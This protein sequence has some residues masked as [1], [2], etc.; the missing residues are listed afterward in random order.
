MS[1]D[2]MIAAAIAASLQDAQPTGV[3][4]PSDR[5]REVRFFDVLLLVLLLL[6]LPLL[7][8]SSATALWYFFYCCEFSSCYRSTH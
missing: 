6:A 1:E 4:A 2:E 3:V 7:M 8:L 5:D